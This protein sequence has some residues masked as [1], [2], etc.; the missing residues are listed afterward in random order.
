MTKSGFK[1][2]RICTALLFLTRIN[3]IVNAY[4]QEGRLEPIFCN[5]EALPFFSA[6]DFT[7]TSFSSIY[8]YLVPSKDKDLDRNTPLDAT[9]S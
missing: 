5:Y 3:I 7:S 9:M 1:A 2:I 8:D 4:S 6:K